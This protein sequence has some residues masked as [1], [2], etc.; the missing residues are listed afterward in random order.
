M[1]VEIWPLGRIKPYSRNPRKNDG[2]AV[3]KVAASITEFG[4]R[5]PIVV[6]AE[7]VI[8]VGDT[9]LKAAKKLALKEAPVVVARELSAEQVKAYRLADNRT[10][11]EAEWDRELLALELVE[12]REGG[13]QDL[14]LHTAFDES[15]LDSLLALGSATPV[16]LTDADEAPDAPLYPRTVRGDLWILGKHLLYCGDATEYGDV[17]NLMGELV[18]DLVLIDPP[19]NVGYVGKTRDA[20]TIKN[21]SM[22]AGPFFDFLRAA[23][24]NLRTL[25]ADGAGIYVWHA[26]T[27]G[28]NFRKSLVDAGWRFA[29]VCVWVKNSM[30]LGRQ[31]YHWQH[32]PV[33]VGWAGADETAEPGRLTPEEADHFEL[34]LRKVY[35]LDYAEQHE[36][37][38]VG[39]KPTA[40]H[41]WYGDRKQTTVWN[42]DRP[43]RSAVHPTMKP[44]EMLKYAI[45][46]ASEAG[47]VVVDTFAG[48][49]STLIACEQ[50]GRRARV[51]ELDPRYCDVIVRR[52]QEFTGKDAFHSDGSRFDARP[53]AALAA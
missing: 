22:G 48:S 52:W 19:Y 50:L 23:F 46:N 13:M 47:Q 14:A 42:F 35:G 53:E 43:S 7:G 2:A 6:D 45:E 37:L 27:E 41:R 26:D 33:L 29:Q 5:Q 32:E 11:E 36:P 10:A 4:W 24:T 51:M 17:K 16:G 49:G 12:L 40:R 21:D 18:A 15:E 31:D 3:D 9:R 1:T 44:V 8:I 39:W 34:L 30:V 38:L 25:A 20:L 28:V